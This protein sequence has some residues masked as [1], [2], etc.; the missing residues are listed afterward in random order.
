MPTGNFKSEL[1]RFGGYCYALN[2][3]HDSRV[4][5]FEGDRPLGKE[6]WGIPEYGTSGKKFPI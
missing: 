1:T 3:K 2:D 6:T 4:P 5:D